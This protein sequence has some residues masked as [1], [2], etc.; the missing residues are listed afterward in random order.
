VRK[1]KGVTCR[2][3]CKSIGMQCEVTAF[4]FRPLNMFNPKFGSFMVNPLLFLEDLTASPAPLP[5]DHGA[6]ALP[7]S[8]C[9]G[10]LECCRIGDDGVGSR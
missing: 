4:V 6:A 7:Y 8:K 1:V 2:V 5:L 10:L 9:L 3:Q